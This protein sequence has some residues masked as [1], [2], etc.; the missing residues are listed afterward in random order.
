MQARTTP[1]APG[2]TVP[3]FELTRPDDAPVEL[4][5]LL[6]ADRTLLYFMRTPTC[7]VCHAH[8]RQMERTEVEDVALAERLVVIVPGDAQD[9]ANVAA[10]HPL[11]SGRIVGSLDAHAAVGLFV[12]AGLQQSGSFV[13]DQSGT[14][15][16][17]RTAT[18]P[19]NAYR[20]A[21]AIGCLTAA[22]R[23]NIPTQ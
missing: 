4:R 11:L 1:I 9:T 3:R 19:V 10:R 14:V 18:V 15:L 6:D 21:E 13:V 22:G 20:E 7:P 2:D 12:R 5:E 8:L 23:G 16:T 17:A